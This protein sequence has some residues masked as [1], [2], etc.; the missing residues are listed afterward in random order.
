MYSLLI[1]ILSTL[2]S[3]GLTGKGI[4]TKVKQTVYNPVT[5]IRQVGN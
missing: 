2:R 4:I 5:V 1:G 3:T